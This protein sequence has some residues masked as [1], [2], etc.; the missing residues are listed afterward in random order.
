[1]G[2][3]DRI[4]ERIE[5]NGFSREQ[6]ASFL[7]V[8]AVTAWRWIKGERNLK[9]KTIKEIAQVLNT[10]SAYLMGETDDPD[11]NVLKKPLSSQLAN[12]SLKD[13][14]KPIL[15][16]GWLEIPLLDPA[17]QACAGG[18][19]GM[20]DIEATATENV[21]VAREWIDG[22]IEPYKPFGI[23]VEGDSMEQAGIPDGSIAIINPNAPVESTDIGFFCVDGSWMVKGVWWRSDGGVDLVPANSNY[24]T[25]SFGKDELESGWVKVVGKVAYVM[26]I[27]KPKRFL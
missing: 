21:V 9:E 5:A 1:M 22:S 6:F 13:G 11:P 12:H 10:T 24:Q 4:R 27:R 17:F 26:Q 16:E 18:G 7:G 14:V 25:L 2:I 3:G 19:N 23:R 20:Y 8:D 15:T